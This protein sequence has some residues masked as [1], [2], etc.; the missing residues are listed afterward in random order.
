LVDTLKTAELLRIFNLEK[1]AL[2]LIEEGWNMAKSVGDIN[3]M[4]Y[5][6]KSMKKENESLSKTKSIISLIDTTKSTYGYGY[7][8]II[9]K[10][11]KLRKY[12]IRVSYLDDVLSVDELVN[13]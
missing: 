11:G 2:F 10:D 6:L 3:D 13:K 4:E 9:V 5:Y 12:Y 1:E 8:S 7:E